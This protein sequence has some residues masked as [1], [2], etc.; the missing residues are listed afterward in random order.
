MNTIQKCPAKAI[1][2]YQYSSLIIK[3]R[4]VCLSVHLNS[5]NSLTD[6]RARAGQ[7][8]SNSYEA[9]HKFY[10][11]LSV[12]VRSSEYLVTNVRGIRE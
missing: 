3:C 1:F 11:L 5:M 9:P 2:V 4:N 8:I 7:T 12:A 6:G 10:C